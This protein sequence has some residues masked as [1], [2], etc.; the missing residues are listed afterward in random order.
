MASHA[1]LAGGPPKNV[2]F[3][4][5][6]ASKIMEREIANVDLGGQLWGV[7]SGLTHVLGKVP[8]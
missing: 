4:L 7:K 5:P 3:S 2:P 6:L 1:R 8:F